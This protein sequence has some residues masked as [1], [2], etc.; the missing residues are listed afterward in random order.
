M[1]DLSISNA[2]YARIARSVED[3]A[4]QHGYNLIICSSEEK[5]EK[6]IQ[7]LKMLRG[8][9]V[10]GVIISSTFGTPPS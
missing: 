6:E 5:E 2:F 3:Y 10:D 7:L 9:Q 4:S 1:M 8:R